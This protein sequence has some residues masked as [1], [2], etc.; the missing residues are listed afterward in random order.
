MLPLPMK[1]LHAFPASPPRGHGRAATR[2]LAIAS[3]ALGLLACAPLAPPPALRADQPELATA[4]VAQAGW[5][6]TRHAVAAAHPLAAEA[7][8][9]LLRAGGSALDA[10]IG[11]QMVLALVEP[12]SSGIG[13]GGFLMHWD[14]RRVQA[15]DGRETA[16]AAADERLFLDAAGRPLPFAE[17][18]VG[19]RSV[20]VPGL[21]RMLEL[22]H[23]Q[24]GRLPW[25]ALFEPAIGLAEQGFEIGPRLHRQLQDDPHLRQD[26]L[27]RRFYYR[28][29]GS[30]LPAGTRLRNPE[31]AA[32][33]RRIAREGS[34]ALHTGEVAQ[35]IVRA[36]R[37]HPRHPGTLTLADLA[38]YRPLEREPLCHD[39][40]AWRLCG[41]P[42]PSSGAIAIGQILGLLAHRPAGQALQAGLPTPQL[43]HDYSEAA[44]LAFADRALYVADPDFV[45]APAGDWRSLLAPA[46]LAERA[47]LIGE[48]AMG[49]APAG[50]PGSAAERTALAPDSS[51]ELPATT[52]ISVIDAAGRAVALTSSIEAQFGARLMVG[53]GAGRAGGFLLN[54][55]L[56][57][58]CCTNGSEGAGRGV[59]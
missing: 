40:Q 28:P 35:A 13:G 59:A 17:A 6:G 15:Y 8:E 29:D 31:L 24:H 11:A 3:L 2:L 48:K 57:G 50:T 12:Q 41:M 32:I 49:R 4:A 20:G 22:A 37:E 26:P 14:G 52:H 36:V 16:P 9:R 5:S 10:A 7:G 47:R 56:T 38:G 23:R 30:A 39:W 42:P 21:V 53:T 27:A 1:P 44:R 18:V 34:S 51:P 19:G 43:L 25:G 54:N 46:Y 55:Q 45:P 58:L 33:L